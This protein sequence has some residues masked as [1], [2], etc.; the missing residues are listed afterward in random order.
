MALI[1]HA[2]I[3][4]ATVADAILQHLAGPEGE[5]ATRRDRHFHPGLGVAPDAL[6]LVPQQ[7]R[8]ESGNLDVLAFGQSTMLRKMASTI[9]SDPPAKGR[10][11]G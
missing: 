1:R 6:G 2:S 5:H 3:L 8:T 11:D 7:E 4:S 9:S 10:P